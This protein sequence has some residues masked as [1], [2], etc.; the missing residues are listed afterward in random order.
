MVLR[1]YA[2]YPLPALTDIG[3]AVAASKHNTAPINHTSSSSSGSKY[4][5]DV[6]PNIN[7]THSRRDHSV[8]AKG[9]GSAHCTMRILSLVTLAFDL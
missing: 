9:D 1:R 8:A 4:S 3:P 2:A 6:L 5:K 7:R